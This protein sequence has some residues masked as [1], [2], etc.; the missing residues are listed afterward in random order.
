MQ[1]DRTPLTQPA[2]M[3]T[4]VL[5]GTLAAL[6]AVYAAGLVWR[7]ASP[8]DRVARTPSNT[9]ETVLAAVE[10]AGLT[11]ELEIQ[12][13]RWLRYSDVFADRAANG[14]MLSE[15][16]Q[17][18][19]AV[20]WGRVLYPTFNDRGEL[21]HTHITINPSDTDIGGP[22]LELI[23]VGGHSEVAGNLKSG[24]IVTVIGRVEGGDRP[25]T[26]PSLKGLAMLRGK[27]NPKEAVISY[28]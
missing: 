24:D 28:R 1:Y 11:D 16:L 12:E 5:A 21:E 15:K 26:V 20:W 17:G 25:R 19:I 22:T 14:G 9:G 18:H 23:W 8:P 3:A 10:K 6:I 4:A 7:Y 27:F 13:P 2:R